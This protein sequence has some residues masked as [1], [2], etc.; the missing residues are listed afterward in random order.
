[1][2]LRL[3]ELV[4]ESAYQLFHYPET[5]KKQDLKYLIKRILRPSNTPKRDFFFW[6]HAMLTQSLEE[7]KDLESLKKYYDRW[8]EKGQPIGNIDHMMNG[9]SL[10]FVYEKTK[11][12][13]YQQAADRMYEYLLQYQKDMKGTLPYRRNHPTH[14]YVDGVGM[15]V[16]FLCRYGS[17]F[18]KK[19]ALDL[20]VKQIREFFEY[21]MDK[22][23]GLPYHGYDLK[24]K[25]KQGIIGW[26]RA[27]GWLLLALADSYEYVNC[28]EQKWLGEVYQNLLIN[29]LHY[30]R[31]DGYFSWQ[32]T[33][34]EGPKDTSA[35]AMIGYALQKAWNLGL[36]MK[37]D[38]LFPENDDRQTRK[39]KSCV[40]G[41]PDCEV[42][43]DICIQN[44]L[45]D[46]EQAIWKSVNGKKIG[47]CSG[48]CEG[49][50]QYPQVYGAYPWSLGPGVRFLLI[51]KE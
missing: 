35:T 12:H 27:V 14:I 10:L 43:A 41:G 36:M 24:T 34:K 2:D 9:Y 38:T 47:D 19:E 28:E 49:F 42:R 44:C 48:E 15:M 45:A 33:A 17:I 6:P 37:E 13:R 8:I 39:K 11:D 23:S 32:L 31:E 51:R 4:E 1:M 18:E 16:P 25:V 29:S 20:A 5:T 30:L 26:G 3:Q 7:A 46:M 22:E 21:G 40:I 50:S